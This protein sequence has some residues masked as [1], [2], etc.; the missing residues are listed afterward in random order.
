M[1]KGGLYILGLIL[2]INI[3]L[4]VGFKNKARIIKLDIP[5]SWPET[6]YDFDEKPLT[7]A[8][9]ELGRHLF[10]DPI[11]SI[12]N[13]ISC[14]S[15][16]SSYTA[17]THV[18]HAV[19]HGVGDSLGN[20]NASVLINLAWNK[21]FMWDGSINHIENQVLAP[22][23]N[24]LEMGDDIVNVVHKLQVSKKYPILFK[25]AFGDTLITGQNVLLAIAQFE[26]TLIST[27]SKYDQVKNNTRGVSFSEQEQ[28]GYNLFK[29]NCSSCHKEPLF[30]SGE[31]EN[32]GL[33][34]DSKL[35]DYG[36]VGVSQ[37]PNDSL[38]FKVPTLRNIEFSFPYMHDGRFKS[39]FE[40]MDHYTSELESG[41]SLTSQLRG[42]LKLSHE[43]KIDIVS[44]LLTLTDKDFLFNPKFE[45]PK[46]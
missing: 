14:A 42:G 18:D 24:P 21:S 34:I 43:N 41:S 22:I 7:K 20:R 9:I 10:Y 36:R 11:L 35:L 17:F 23:H 3:I 44:F 27:N 6:N 1:I 12:D 13:S 31:F 33:P 4:A 46:K 30:T 45:F 2:S 32:N 39:L 38:K 25:L 8:K 15:C 16:H 28:R 19:S 37:N 40:V 5:K 26:L 29:T